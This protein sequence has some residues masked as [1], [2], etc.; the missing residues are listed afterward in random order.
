MTAEALVKAIIPLLSDT[1]EREKM[2]SGYKQITE[3]L[4]KQGVY[5]RTAKLIAEK[6]F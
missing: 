5:R 1:L 2:L 4:G 6:S 3:K